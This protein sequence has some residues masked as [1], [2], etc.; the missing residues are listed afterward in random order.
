MAEFPF[1]G[2]ISGKLR[3]SMKERLNGISLKITSSRSTSKKGTLTVR[4][5]NFMG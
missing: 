4:G 3:A 1:G 2:S 5:N